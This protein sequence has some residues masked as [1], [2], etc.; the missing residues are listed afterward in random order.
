[1]R[2][3]GDSGS[4]VT[5][6]MGNSKNCD[7]CSLSTGIR[8]K[9]SAVVSSWKHLDLGREVAEWVSDSSIV[10]TKHHDQGDLEKK[11][12]IWGCESR[13]ITVH[14]GGEAAGAAS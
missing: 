1:M 14:H 4:C 2:N 11:G 12:F 10:T 9:L 6:V 13:G 8:R 5:G 7:G 3:K